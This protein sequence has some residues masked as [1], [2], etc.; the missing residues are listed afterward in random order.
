MDRHWIFVSFPYSDFNAGT[1]SEIINKILRSGKWPIGKYTVYRKQLSKGDRTLFYQ[2]GNEGRKFVGSGELF[3]GLQQDDKGTSFH[4]IVGNLEL[5]DSPV[6]MSEVL[7]KLSFIK[8][9]SHWGLYLQGGVIR[10]SE[11]DYRTV[12]RRAKHCSR[13]LRDRHSR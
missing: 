13:R 1:I 3:S 8:D 12:V 6:P 7:D 9:K 5:W 4:V 10:V 2:A 11:E